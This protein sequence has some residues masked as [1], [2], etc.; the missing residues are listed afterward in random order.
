M[1]ST[2]LSKVLPVGSDTVATNKSVKQR[3]PA[4]L[5]WNHSLPT[6]RTPHKKEEQQ[7]TKSTKVFPCTLQEPSDQTHPLGVK[8]YKKNGL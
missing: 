7:V 8:D 1:V 4:V 2:F 3:E 5:W 6:N